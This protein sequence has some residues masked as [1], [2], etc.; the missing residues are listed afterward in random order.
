MRTKHLLFSLLGVFL[1]F[2]CERTPEVVISK[3]VFSGY[4]QKGPFINGST[5]T[6]TLLDRNLNQTGSVFS[7]QIIDNLGTFERRNI[8]FASN[9]VELRANGFYFNE[10]TGATSNAPLT[11]YALADIS[12]VDAVNVNVLTHLERQRVIHLIQNDGLS[13]STAKRQARNEVLGIFKFTLPNDVASQSLNITEDALL[14]AVSVILQG[15]LSTGDLSQLLAD[16]STDIR[17]TGRL[18]NRALGSQLMNNAVF[19]NLEQVISN[20]ERRYAELGVEIEIN[21]DELN[22]YV[23]SFIRNSGFEQTSFITYPEYGRFGRNILYEGFVEGRRFQYG[24]PLH[25]ISANVPSGSSLKIIIRSKLPEF[26]VCSVWYCGSVFSEL[27]EICPNCGGVNTIQGHGGFEWGGRLL[28]SED[29]W[30]KYPWDNSIRGNVLVVIEAGKPADMG[31]ALA[32]D[33]IIEFFENGATEPTR[34][35]EVRVR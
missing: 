6:I 10:V 23:Q 34:V 26:I 9:F 31:V 3:P 24:S 33:F 28:G 30:R 16:I 35:R 17:T 7:T 18:N 1:L 15:H 20:L 25:S 22:H 14:L 21:F 12:E 11:L 5:V 8:E 32:H 19:L 2:A 4:V 27:H 13:F 29:N